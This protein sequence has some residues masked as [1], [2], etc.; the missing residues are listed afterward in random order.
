MSQYFDESLPATTHYITGPFL[1]DGNDAQQYHQPTATDNHFFPDGS[2]HYYGLQAD[3]RC[4]QQPIHQGL[5]SASW[6]S[7]ETPQDRMCCQPSRQQHFLPHYAH[8]RHHA[9]FGSETA[10]STHGYAPLDQQK[11]QLPLAS[12][13]VEKNPYRPGHSTAAPN[14]SPDGL[15]PG[16]TASSKQQ[17][18]H[19]S[20]SRRTS[21]ATY[22]HN[23]PGPPKASP[24]Q[25]F[26][27]ASGKEFMRFEYT[28]NR[29]KTQVE[30][31]CDIEHIDVASLS[32]AF[33]RD[34]ACYKEAGDGNIDEA[35]IRARMYERG[36]TESEMRTRLRRM[37][38]EVD[39]NRIGWKL[40]TLNGDKLAGRK[41]MIQRAA[42]S[43]RNSG[44]DLNKHSRRMNR[45]IMK[46]RR[47]AADEE[48]SR[49]E[50]TEPIKEEYASAS[51]TDPAAQSPLAEALQ[52][53]QSYGFGFGF[54]PI[55]NGE[56]P[57]L[58]VYSAFVVQWHEI[59]QF[60][61][62]L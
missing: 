6:S 34:N 20:R 53:Y 32:T 31:R 60:P 51:P 54:G 40:V 35:T 26:T 37:K 59:P 33:K 30:L 39:C 8:V 36:K 11:S 17:V 45:E 58:F 4:H 3:M 48:A 55:K 57:L 10:A 9:E 49:H 25:R 22:P 44:A 56:Q 47:R 19:P 14:A 15:V 7:L 24:V 41:G 27:D 16:P 18:V 52:P 62:T 5:P 29:K 61:C 46:A 43:Y 21:R 2:A 1:S 42:D 50:P 23:S 38:Y 13:S 28:M 12:D